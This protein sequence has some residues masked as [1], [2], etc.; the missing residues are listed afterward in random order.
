MTSRE[1]PSCCDIFTKFGGEDARYGGN[2]SWVAQVRPKHATLGA[3][4]LILRRHVESL[5]L[6]TDAE[7]AG[8]GAALRVVDGR[9]KKSFSFDKLNCLALMM[10]DRHVHFHVIPRYSAP[11][12]FHG[13]DWK[14]PGWPK[15]PELGVTQGEAGDLAAMRL[16]LSGGDGSDPLEWDVPGERTGDS[17]SKEKVD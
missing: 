14:D 7:W 6:L 2:A 16:E 4:V 13:T 11:R 10:V 17:S 5:A 12:S 1:I 9:L 3:S 8:L 15:G